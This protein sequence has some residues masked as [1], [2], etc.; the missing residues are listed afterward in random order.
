MHVAG[1]QFDS[2]AITD[3]DRHEHN[4][5]DSVRNTDDAFSD[6]N[7]V[8]DGQADRIADG[9]ADNNTKQRQPQRIRRVPLPG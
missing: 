8:A 9:Q 6:S 5:S 7:D 1:Q 3:D 4:N 2:D